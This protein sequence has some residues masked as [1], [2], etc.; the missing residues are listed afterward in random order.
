MR[1]VRTLIVVAAV[2]VLVIVLVSRVPGPAPRKSEP[3]ID[4][5]PPPPPTPTA[6]PSDGKGAAVVSPEAPIRVEERGT[7]TIVFT[8]GP[9]GIAVGGGVVLQVSPFWGWSPPQSFDAR[10]PGYTSVTSSDPSV[11]VTVRENTALHWIQ[12]VVAGAPLAPGQTITF[13]YGDTGDGEN[14]TA[15]AAADRFA[16]RE[17]ELLVKVDG[18]G[19]GYYTAIE[20]SPRL[21]VRAAPASHLVITGPSL[22]R[23]GEAVELRVAALDFR[24]NRAE[25]FTG[26]VRLR[27]LEAG[28]EHPE[29]ISF[30]PEDR[31]AVVVAARAVDEG[32]ARVVA[33]FA[34]DPDRFAVSNPIVVTSRPLPA[35][36][37]WGDLQIHSGIS[38]G[39]G[40]PEEIFA[41]AREVA[42]LD[43]AALT[44]HDAHGVF[45]LDESPEVW[46]RI[47]QATREAYEPGRF[48]TFPGFEWTSWTFGHKHVLF[49]DDDA[50]LLSN[51]SRDTD[52]PDKLWSRLPEGRAMTISHHTLG[53]P[54]PADW[55]YHDSRLEPL[56]EIC[57]IHGSSEG[58]GQPMSVRGARAGHGVQD[59][60]ARGYRLGFLGSGDT[61]NGHPGLGDTGSP[62]GG[63]AGI[64]AA[65]CT[66]EAIWD[67]LR[68]R[69]VYAS[70]GPRVVLDVTLN[71]TPMGGLA[72]LDSPQARRA[73][74]IEAYSPLR[75]QA[76]EIFKNNV[77]IVREPMDQLTVGLEMED[78]EPAGDGDFYYVRL[79]L[80]HD[81]M[82]W[83][84]P[85]W[86]RI[87]PDAPR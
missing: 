74:H 6:S 43:V 46:R 8:A 25:D 61:H 66:R 7:W 14:P 80:M 32:Y 1:S 26:L 76:V 55:T 86:V 29:A 41:Y 84:S 83:S 42:G 69:R 68:A 70:S 75:I 85:V 40:T 62:L 81:Q 3:E 77:R 87:G 73:F 22:V 57:S 79:R 27:S 50:P 35:R 20:R 51:R 16:E 58:V 33:S 9:D 56:V 36:L 24:M 21:E 71:E 60:L 65:E 72:R 67:A 11:H 64:Y 30:V 38:D 2:L 12:A 39:T 13:V 31:G 49:L 19:D 47:Q 59:A 28:L 15:A 48:V 18:D 17:E 34:E 53:D 5:R 54:V 23:P 4:R 82:V 44:D 52:T 78:P 37:F 45:A 10:A 63:V